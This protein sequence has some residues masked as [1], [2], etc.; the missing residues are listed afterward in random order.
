MQRVTY[1]RRHAYNTKSNKIRVSKTPGGRNVVLYRKK[2]GRV[3]NTAELLGE[4]DSD[5]FIRLTRS[6]VHLDIVPSLFIYF[7]V[8][9]QAVATPELPCLELKLLVPMN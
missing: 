4:L 5:W 1:R 3:L 9:S 6:L 7:Q 2:K 8:P